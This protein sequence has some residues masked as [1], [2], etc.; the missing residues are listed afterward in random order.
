[1][2]VCSLVISLCYID[3]SF[4]SQAALKDA[5]QT[6][7]GVDKE[8]TALRSEVEVCV[9]ICLVLIRSVSCFD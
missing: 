6:N 8:I 3:L 4:S 7:I 2:D 1:M 9:I 5:K